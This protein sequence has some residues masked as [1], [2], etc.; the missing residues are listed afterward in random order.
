I[1]DDNTHMMGYDLHSLTGEGAMSLERITDNEMEDY[2][3]PSMLAEEVEVSHLF[4]V[5]N[6]TL[7]TGREKCSRKNND[8]WT[9]EE[10]TE[11]VQGVSKQGVGKWSQLK[12]YYFSTSIRT[13]MHLK[14]KWRNLVRACRRNSSKKKVLSLSVWQSFNLLANVS[15]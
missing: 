5:R 3:E 12:R 14:D 6:T 1:V 4:G 10:M 15:S 8:H 9:E 7:M 11:L 13:A 2:L